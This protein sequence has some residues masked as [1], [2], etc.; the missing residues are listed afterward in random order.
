MDIKEAQDWLRGE[1]SMCNIVP[2]DPFET[3][4]ERIARGDAAMTEQAYWVVRAHND[5]RVA[6]FDQLLAA[7]R[8]AKAEL[9]P[10]NHA[11][12]CT[13]ER[14]TA[15]WTVNAAIDAAKQ[16]EQTDGL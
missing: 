5:R 11:P 6:C 1:R 14:C 3:W 16:G 15:W 9:N 12:E 2:Q 4:Q 13:C 8:I 7:L 10:V